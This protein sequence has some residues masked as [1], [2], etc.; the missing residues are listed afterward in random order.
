MTFKLKIRGKQW[1][2]GFRFLSQP[3]VEIMDDRTGRGVELPLHQPVLWSQFQH[4]VGIKDV[5]EWRPAAIYFCLEDHRQFKRGGDTGI[6]EEAPRRLQA[7][8]ALH[9]DLDGGTT[10]PAGL[11]HRGAHHVLA[12][13]DGHVARQ[14]QHLAVQGGSLGLCQTALYPPGHILLKEPLFMLQTGIE[15]GNC[16]ERS[17]VLL[18]YVASIHSKYTFIKA[19]YLMLLQR[20]H[21]FFSDKSLKITFNTTSLTIKL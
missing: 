8:F 11:I 20:L 16:G 21:C 4:F 9:V 6:C 15:V 10:E 7:F 14:Q 5:H 3:L 13:P 17:G 19:S 18:E 12:H 1:N 2:R